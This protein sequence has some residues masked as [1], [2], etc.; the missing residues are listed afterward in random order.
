MKRII[1]KENSEILKQNLKYKV[2]GNNSKI[3]EILLNEQNHICAYTE[4]YIE[5]TDQADIDHFNPNLKGKTKDNYKNWFAIK[6]K[7]NKKK[8]SSWENPML[9]PTDKDFEERIIYDNGD[10][11]LNKLEDIP[12]KNLLK[13]VNLNDDKLSDQRKRYIARRRKEIK[14]S[15]LSAQDFFD[16]YMKD[17]PEGVKFIRAIEEEFEIKINFNIK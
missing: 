9:Y 13:L 8:S 16:D 3:S 14:E 1:K 2:K 15:S 17:Y 7:W 12:A 6:T 10:Y 5:S 11:I 4:T